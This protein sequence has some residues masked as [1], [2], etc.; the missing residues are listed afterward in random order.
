MSKHVAA[1]APGERFFLDLSLVKATK[2]GSKVARNKNWRFMVDERTGVTFTE[3]YATKKGM[4]EPI[5]ELLHKMI[6]KGTNVKYIRMDNAEENK[7]LQA[8]SQSKD[9]KLLLE[10]EYTA[11]NTPQ[12]NSSV[13][14]KFAAIA[15]R[16]RVKIH[17]GNMP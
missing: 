10:F 17:R 7:K 15:S 9:W 6:S 4:I 2:D 12:Q 16:G 13:E 11:R 1:T 8:R 14:V 3:F 5:L